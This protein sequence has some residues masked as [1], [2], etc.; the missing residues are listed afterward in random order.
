MS[1]G[2]GSGSGG[3]FGGDGGLDCSAIKF[4]AFLS[5][6]NPE[7][8]QNVK[9]GDR[10]PIELRSDPRSLVVVLPDGRVLG[11]ITRKVRELLRCIQQRVE[12]MATIKNINGGDVEVFV[13]PV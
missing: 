5:S 3:G 8:L 10:L 12:F 1:G 11:A 4:D 7:V 13:E 9:E 6:V 2:G